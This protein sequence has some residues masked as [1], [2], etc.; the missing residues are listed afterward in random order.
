MQDLTAAA[1][2]VIAERSELYN[3]KDAGDPK[4]FYL[5]LEIIFLGLLVD[6]LRDLTCPSG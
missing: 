4:L 5:T 6:T 3:K 2:A 1:A